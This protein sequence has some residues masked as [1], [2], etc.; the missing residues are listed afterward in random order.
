MK[1]LLGGEEGLNDSG[2]SVS[3]L[4]LNPLFFLEATGEVYQGDS[5]RVHT[6]TKRSD[7]SY[8]G[9][10][11]GYRDITEGT[12]LDLGTSFADGHNDAGARFHDP[13]LRRRRD[14]PLPAAAARDLPAFLGRTELI[15]SHRAQDIG[16]VSAFGMYVSGEYQFARRWFA[17]ARYDQSRACDRSQLT[18]QGRL[19][20]ADLLAERV[21]PGPRPVSPDALRGGRHAPTSCC[22][23]SSSPSART[24]RTSF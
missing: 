23:S 15:W 11:R 21:Q 13:A 4:I 1:N 5:G 3:K 18:R 20:A 10:L 24:A 7:L 12:N 8:V 9:R 22:S 17:G 6:A 2:I 19:A 14:V 16:D